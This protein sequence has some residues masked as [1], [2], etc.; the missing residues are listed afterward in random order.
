[1]RIAALAA[2]LAL[3]ALPAAGAGAAEWTTSYGPLTLPAVG[4]HLPIYAPYLRD[5]G[6]IKGELRV[7]EGRPVLIG[8]WVEAGAAQACDTP[9]DGSRYWGNVTLYFD[10]EFRRFTGGWDYCGTGE[11]FGDWTGVRGAARLEQ[12]AR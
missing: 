4:G 9:L 12:R 10:A 1:M 8:H 7:V 3:P 6:R 2:L 5:G 11:I